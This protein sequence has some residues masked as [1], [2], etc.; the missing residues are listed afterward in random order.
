[1]TDLLK[2]NLV[3]NAGIVGNSR[4]LTGSQLKRKGRGEGRSER[5]KLRRNCKASV[6]KEC[7]FCIDTTTCQ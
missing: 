7:K 5:V 3:E 4:K 6:V 1:M 2:G